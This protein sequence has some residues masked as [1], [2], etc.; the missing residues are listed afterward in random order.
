MDGGQKNLNCSVSADTANPRS[1]AILRAPPAVNRVVIELLTGGA[2]W[3]L[4]G[5]PLVS[6][7]H[8]VMSVSCAVEIAV[9]RMMP[10]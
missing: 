2:D 7:S 4:V 3:P 5:V 8:L 1:N 6:R 9:L 10:E